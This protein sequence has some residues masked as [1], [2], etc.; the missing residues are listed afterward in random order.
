MLS[1]EIVNYLSSF[2]KLVFA[3][4]GGKDSMALLH[5]ALK[6]LDKNKI[7]V[8]TVHHNLRGEEGERDRDF[9]VSFCNKQGIECQVYE[10]NIKEFCQEN[11]YTIEQGARIRRHKI[12]ESI[13]ANKK[14]D[15]VVLAHHKDDQ[16]ESILMHI[17]RGCGLKG[18]CGMELDTG[19][20]LRPLL[21]TSSEE[22]KQYIEKE[23]IEFVQDST[24][25]EL[26]YSRNKIRNVVI[27][28]I[29]KVYPNFSTNILRL[30]EISN[31]A[32]KYISK[33]AP[34][35]YKQNNCVYLKVSELNE[36]NIATEQ[37]VINAVE[38]IATRVDLEKCHIDQVF[39][40][41]EK[42]NGKTINLPFNV[43]AVKEYDKIA[44]YLNQSENIETTDFQLGLVAFGDWEIDISLNNNGGLKAD[45]DK[46]GKAIIRTRKQGDSF[47]RFKGGRKPLGKYLTDV[48]VAKMQRDNLPI[49][50]RDNEVLAVLPIE[51]SDGISVDDSTKN[52]VYLK[53]VS[54]RK[55]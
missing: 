33:Q 38:T 29:E 37:A 46:I 15:R 51:I 52:I 40:L 1:S 3:V 16:A 39:D 4:S 8:V 26:E 31:E 23:H 30:S 25:F 48:K 7:S 44:F 53:A 11:G 35:V 41:I 19:V 2:N 49:L 22:I 54:K 9:V 42:E 50:A 21:Y 12:F 18:L 27:K 24:N 32:V 20:I 45:L 55:D 13:V 17:F 47:K 14:A 36:K 5:F 43:V 28:E 34:N 10:E 6:N